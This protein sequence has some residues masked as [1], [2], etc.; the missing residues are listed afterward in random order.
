MS[1][2]VTRVLFLLCRTSPDD[3]RKRQSFSAKVGKRTVEKFSSLQ[4]HHVLPVVIDDTILRRRSFSAC[5][6]AIGGALDRL[7]CVCI[8]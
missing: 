3:P 7:R 8:K 4:P 2:F 5:T 6:C 1:S